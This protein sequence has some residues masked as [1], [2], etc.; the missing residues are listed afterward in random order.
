MLIAPTGSLEGSAKQVVAV[1]LWMAVWWMTEAA[2]LAVTSMLPL[3]LFPLLNV[4]GVRHVAP[5]YS[6]HM[7]FLFLGGFILALAVER[8]SPLRCSTRSGRRPNGWCG[9][10]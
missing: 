7:I 5:N 2:P 10:F 3:V 8:S 6:N 9:V 1:V 4:R